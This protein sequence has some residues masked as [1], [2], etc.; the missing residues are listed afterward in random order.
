M[1]GKVLAGHRRRANLTQEGLAERTGLSVRS[2]RDLENGRVARPRPSTLELL[3]DA[4]NLS[5]AEREWFLAAAHPRPASPCQLPLDVPGFAGRD[6]ELAGLD[7]LLT[8]AAGVVIAAIAGL[9]GVGKTALA[10]HWAHRVAGRF[11]DGQLYVDLRG[12]GPAPSVADPAEVL[13][14]FLEA[15]DQPRWTSRRPASRPAPTPGPRFTAACSAAG[16]CSSCSTTPATT[17]R[18]ARCC[19]APAPASCW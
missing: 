14:A 2:I 6:A 8:R 4:L 1:F 5:A 3:T 17:T 18:C 19:P 9:A 10:V 13:R 7:E 11:P 16:G 15:L 12:F